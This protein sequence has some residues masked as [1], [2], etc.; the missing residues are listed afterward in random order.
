MLPIS[1]I[2]CPSDF[3]EPSLAA[4]ETA[5]ELAV[6]FGSQLTVL[7]VVSPMPPVPSGHVLGPFDVD[8]YECQ[9]VDDSRQTLKKMVRKRLGDIQANVR[10]ESGDA[11]MC[12]VDTAADEKSGLIVIA[13]HGQTG[14]RRLVFGSV[15]EKVVRM[16]ACPVL[17]VRVQSG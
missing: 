9:L 16:A 10:I 12:I 17:T 3:S 15:A 2:L 11:A 5:S 13:T 14:W 7:H 8:A 1:K 6:H 4:L